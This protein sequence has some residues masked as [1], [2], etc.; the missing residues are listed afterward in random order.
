MSKII[1]VLFKNRKSENRFR[2]K[3]QRICNN[4]NP[5]NIKAVQS[6]I[7][8]YDGVLWGISNPNEN[9]QI[10]E[11]N[12]LFGQAFGTSKN[13]NELGSEKP[14]G[15]YAIFRADDSKFEIVSDI[16][17]TKSIWYFKNDEIFISSSS[18]RAIIQ[19][20]G[21]FNFNEKTIPWMVSNGLLGPGQ[22]WD[23]NISLLPPESILILDRNNWRLSLNTQEIIFK[24][25]QNTDKENFE[26]FNSTLTS[27][28]NKMSLD[29]SKWNLTL[30][31]GYDSRGILFGLP[32]RDDK[33]NLIKTLT[34]GLESALDNPD[35]D[36]SIA[37]KL[38]DKLEIPHR[39]YSTDTSSKVPLNTVLDR[40]LKNGEGRID[41][42]GGYMDGFAIWKNLF[43]SGV[44]GII[45]GDEVFGSYN[46][47]SEFHMKKFM[48]LSVP[49][50]YENL[51]KIKY[52]R[53]NNAVLP[54]NF[55][56]K[57]WE[58]SEMWRDRLY[59]S[60]LVPT[61]L[62]AL[63]DLKQPYLEQVNPLLSRKIVS[64]IREIPD[65]LR[66]EKKIFKKYVNSY[67]TTIKFANSP[68][69][70]SMKDIF[71]QNEMV[72]MVKEELNSPMAKSIFSQDLLS[73]VLEN[74]TTSHN[75]NQNHKNLIR[76][77]KRMIPKRIKKRLLKETFT[78]NAD[79]N[80]VGF[81]LFMITK[82]H[83][84]LL[85]DSK[86]F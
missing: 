40:F 67:H 78:P 64:L 72:Q 59:H 69:I 19:F 50:D 55:R 76:R 58:T 42:I 73:Y 13:W 46:F 17:G 38:A 54:E 35:N 1:Y 85:K 27:V 71:R 8:G 79:M 45:R 11:N 56:K 28:F 22:S 41:H 53:N 6:K 66:T 3:I 48:G 4:L 49:N 74:M 62:S 31:G 12:I 2:D 15:N 23:K 29:Y 86:Q 61:F 80:M 75:K 24:P 37:K 68:A 84:L 36:A 33:G 47:V 51:N 7:G 32:R 63:E 14:D 82:M 20:L 43:E 81:R 9:I 39:Y 60:H 57:D 18:Q 83:K 10:N 77:L 16:L 5:E 30:S 65:H 21:K 25:N 70:E 34:W 44:K 52:F 26:L